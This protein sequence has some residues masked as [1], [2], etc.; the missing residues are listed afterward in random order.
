[1][2]STRERTLKL[3][4]EKDAEIQQLRSELYSLQGVQDS[5]LL[6]RKRNMDR[7]TSMGSESSSMH[8]INDGSITQHFGAA[9]AGGVTNT[10]TGM[11]KYM[12]VCLKPGLCYWMGDISFHFSLHVQILLVSLTMMLMPG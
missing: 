10:G 6:H 4:A 7:S 5:S 8:E 11:Y 3:L 12:P 9:A 1:M 2:H